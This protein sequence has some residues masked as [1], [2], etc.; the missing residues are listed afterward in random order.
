MTREQAGL[1]CSGRRRDREGSAGLPGCLLYRLDLPPCRYREMFQG[2]SFHG[3]D[4][5]SAFRV[6]NEA[7]KHPLQQ[8]CALYSVDS[9]ENS[10]RQLQRR[11][12]VLLSFQRTD[13]DYYVDTFQQLLTEITTAPILGASPAS[14]T[15]G[16]GGN[17]RRP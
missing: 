12:K 1:G 2:I 3:R 5:G 9:T 8:L 17:M 7:P 6:I 16:R 10:H 14:C 4:L 15:G 11:L 13:I